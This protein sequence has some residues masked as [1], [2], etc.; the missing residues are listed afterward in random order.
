ME[1]EP[2]FEDLGRGAE[3]GFG[4]P[5]Q[6]QGHR[7]QHRFKKNSSETNKDVGIPEFG[8]DVTIRVDRATKKASVIDVIR[9]ITGK[10]SRAAGQML[11]RLG[12]DYPELDA[13][14]VNQSAQA[15]Q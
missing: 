8:V 2:G 5:D 14:C 9:M 11:I 12:K 4:V 15:E 6:D 1:P 13:G 10:P 7:L 3:V